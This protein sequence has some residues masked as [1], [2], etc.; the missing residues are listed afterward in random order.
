MSLPITPPV[1]A[2]PPPL[3][4]LVMVEVKPSA[5]KAA[6]LELDT[7]RLAAV[8]VFSVITPPLLTDDPE[9][10]ARASILP[11]SVVM[12]S[13]MLIWFGPD[14]PEAMK[15]SV[16]PSTVMV[17]P[18]PKPDE[19]TWAPP[20]VAEP[21]STVAPEIAGEDRTLPPRVTLVMPRAVAA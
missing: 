10:P 17:S 18:A 20:A 8:P 11:S 5:A 15:V 12:L 2:V 6:L 4:F 16:W 14:A 1:P 19:S 9:A 21:L 3:R 7:D 13:V